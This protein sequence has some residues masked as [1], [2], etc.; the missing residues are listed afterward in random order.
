MFG[1]FKPKYICAHCGQ[2]SNGKPTRTGSSLI[3]LLGLLFAIIPGLLY[4]I[5]GRKTIYV[6]PHCKRNELVELKTPRG[7]KLEAE[8]T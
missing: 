2:K 1:W 7:K 8:F 6:C 5:F 4:E 3:T